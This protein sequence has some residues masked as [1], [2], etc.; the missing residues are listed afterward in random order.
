MT[1]NDVIPPLLPHFNEIGSISVSQTLSATVLASLSFFVIIFFYHRHKKK[2]KN[3]YFR[4]LI[5]YF[6]EKVYEFLA[7]IWW[8]STNSKALTLT[9][10]L[11]FYVL[12]NNLFGLI[13]D[14]IV[15]VRPFAH[16]WF[17]PST[18]DMFFNAT[19]AVATI[20]A[21]F[22]YGFVMNGP[23]FIKKYFPINGMGIVEKVDKW[24]KVF[25]KFLDILLWLLIWFIELLSEIW[26]ILSLTLRLFWNMFVWMLLLTLLLFSM[27]SL[28][29]PFLVPA[30]IFAYESAISLLQAMIFATLAT[31]YFRLAGDSGH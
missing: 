25:T 23:W 19:M 21:M 20:I 29:A 1:I 8:P 4:Q 26:K 14:M 12:W 13:W 18:T 15:L 16:H 27:K 5:E 31:V 10:T 9:T 6:Y 7:N 28:V 3:S 24:R 17:R 2:S 22:A 11:F 30:T